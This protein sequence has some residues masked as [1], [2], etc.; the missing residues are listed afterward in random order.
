MAGPGGCLLL[1]ATI[2]AFLGI[3]GSSSDFSGA[4]ELVP[5]GADLG[6]LSQT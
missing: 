4:T 2:S 6:R 5:C 3:L 1:T